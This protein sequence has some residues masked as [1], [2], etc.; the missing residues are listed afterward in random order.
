[1][2]ENNTSEYIVKNILLSNSRFKKI[3]EKYNF[4]YNIDID[5]NDKNILFIELCRIPNISYSYIKN[6]IINNS[7]DFSKK[8]NLNSSAYEYIVSNF[9]KFNSDE[10]YNNIKNSI[11]TLKLFIKYITRKNRYILLNKINEKI[12]LFIENKLVYSSLKS[13]HIYIKKEKELLLNNT[14]NIININSIL[15]KIEETT[16]NKKIYYYIKK[17]LINIDNINNIHFRNIILTLNNVLNNNVLNN[18]VLNNS[19]LNNNVLNNS[20]LNNNVLN[21]NV[22]NLDNIE[23]LLL[24]INKCK[25]KLNDSNNDLEKLLRNCDSNI[26]DYIFFLNN[27]NNQLV[28]KEV[29]INFISKLDYTIKSFKNIDILNLK[30]GFIFGLSNKKNKKDY[31]LKYQP[32]KSVM[33]LIIN[34]YLKE[35][36]FSNFLIPLNFFINSDNS[37]FYIIEKYRTDL[38]KYFNL[39]EYVNKFLTFNE[40]IYITKF[41]MES[42][43]ILHKNNIIHSDLKLENIILNHDLSSSIT[44]LKIIDFDV[45]LFNSIPSHLLPLSEKYQ[46][47]FNNKKIR[48]TRIYMLK[49]ELMSFKNDIYSLGV[50]ALVLLYKNTKL[51]L[52]LIKKSLSNDNIKNKKIIIKYQSLIKKMTHLRDVIEEDDNK[53]KMLNLISNILM[54]DENIKF[55]DNINIVKFK[56]YKEFIINCIKTRYNIEELISKYNF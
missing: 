3:F 19:V 9:D 55:F 18:S 35:H 36:K 38:Y 50:V 14:S 32:N 40:I 34:S 31:L 49:S 2:S 53:I 56:F 51:I 29:I 42:I 28:S 17:L 8:D 45:A 1:M 30:R 37:Y 16:D 11:E 26:Y 13:L 47:V 10:S 27:N 23:E 21:N 39:L 48:G 5:V 44:D 12:K 7:I 6:C 54:K 20:V 43:N 52:T 41:I 4:N 22:L 33:E 46:K 15:K 24:L 25:N